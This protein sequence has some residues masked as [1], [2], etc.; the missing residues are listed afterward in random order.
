MP[1]ITIIGGGFAGVEAAWAAANRGCTVTLYEMRPNRQTA[2]H[3]TSDLAELVCSNSFKSN[4]LTN[5]AGVLKEEMRRLGSLILPIAARHSVPAGEAL[6]VDREPFSREVT[7]AIDAHPNITIIREEVTE[8]PAGRP[9]IIATGPLTSEALA[10][11]IQSLTGA[12]ALYFYDAVAPTV[13][14]ESLDMSKVFRASRRGRGSGLEALN[15]GMG[16]SESGGD[17]EVNGEAVDAPDVAEQKGC[18]VN[19]VESADY[20]NCPLNKEEYFALYEALLTAEQSISHNPDDEKIIYFEMCMP[21]EEIAR[22]GPRTLAFGPMKPV[23]L[24]DPRTGRWPY[25]VVQLRQENKDGTLWGLVGFQTRLKW[26]EQK[27]VFRLI[28]G[29]EN[30]EFVR[31]G[32]MH[33]NTY[34]NAPTVLDLNMQV[35]SSPGVFLAGQM[36]GVEGYLESAAIGILAGINAARV[37]CDLKP[38]SPPRESALGSLCAY[39]TETEPKR[40]APMNAN[41]GIMPELPQ[42]IRDK[43]ERARLKGEIALKAID[44]FILNNGL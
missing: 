1:H 29:L 2:V 27:R 19:P 43:R 41:F 3:K 35:K 16:E 39:L 21:V 5:A 17:G 25:A 14:L 7:E 9:L 28:P 38:V 10:P 6:A 24:D 4:L 13:T 15:W 44:R 33:R 26:P 34:V 36:T 30:A 32:V 8:L 31:Y 22:R 18:A 40:F 11:H 12:D 37:A 23:G 20:L 42:K